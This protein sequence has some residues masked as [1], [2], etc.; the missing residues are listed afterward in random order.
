MH[1]PT[2]M[3]AMVI[4]PELLPDDFGDSCC[5]PQLCPVAVRPCPAEKQP[6]Q[7][8]PLG[9]PQLQRASRREAHPQSVGA[10]STACPEPP[11][12]GTG[13]ARDATPHFVQ[14]Q[15]RVPQRQRSP[16]TVLEQIRTSLLQS[17]HRWSV[18]NPSGGS[19]LRP[20]KSTSR[21]PLW[22]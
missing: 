3:I 14:R 16:A 6:Q 15:A 13:G 5:G 2:D 21:F 8:P 19:S 17:G 22:W 12:H 7:T 18:R 9:L 20:L 4:H 11:Q 1:Q 10:P